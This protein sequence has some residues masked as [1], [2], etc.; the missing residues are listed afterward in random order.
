MLSREQVYTMLMLR[1]REGTLFSGLPPE[2]I[3]RISYF[4]QDLNEVHNITGSAIDK[5]LRLAAD[6]QE[7]ALNEL[8]SMLE[9]EPQLLLQAGNVVTRAGLLVTCT[10]ILEF[11]ITSVDPVG[12]ARVD[13]YFS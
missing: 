6:G 5:A 12:V 1:E 10:T 9:K 7:E 3:Q 11:F 2:V 8:T 4:G 13:P